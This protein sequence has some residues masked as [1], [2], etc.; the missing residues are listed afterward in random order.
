MP[1]ITACACAD[2][3]AGKAVLLKLAVMTSTL[4]AV[5]AWA[6][7]SLVAAGRART[8]I[9][10]GVNSSAASIRPRTRNFI[11]GWSDDTVDAMRRRR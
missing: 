10:C 11:P 2:V 4:L 5:T 9:R 8:V 7:T 1:V 6:T 3:I